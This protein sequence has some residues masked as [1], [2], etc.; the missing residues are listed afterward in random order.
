MY[1]LPKMHNKPVGARFIVTSKNCCSTESLSGIVSK[2]F[3]IIFNTLGSFND[4]SFFYSGCRKFWIVQNYVPII[5]IKS[6]L[7]WKYTAEKVENEK[8]M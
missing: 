5:E 7:R 3:K 8:N 2:V 1:W 4:K 6:M